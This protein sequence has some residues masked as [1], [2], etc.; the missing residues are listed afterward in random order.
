MSCCSNPDNSK[1]EVIPFDDRPIGYKDLHHETVDVLP[2]WPPGARPPGARP[3][4]PRP[5]GGSIKKQYSNGYDDAD[6]DRSCMAA[7]GIDLCECV[8]DRPGRRY[9]AQARE[10]RD[11]R[12]ADRGLAPDELIIADSKP[13]LLDLDHA[14]KRG[15][16]LVQLDASAGAFLGL[17][18]VEIGT[19]SGTCLKIS[20]VWPD[21][22]MH[23]WNCRNPEGRR[24]AEGDLILSVNSVSGDSN[25][26]LTE[27]HETIGTMELRVRKGTYKEMFD[28]LMEIDMALEAAERSQAA[29]ERD[30]NNRRLKAAANDADRR[31]EELKRKLQEP[32]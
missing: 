4:P 26:L 23:G 2:E 27:F 13:A 20:K 8:E 9:P 24:V 31:V 10:Q 1:E 21:S 14:P 22:V 16:F 28:E 7:S 11:Y 15:D 3:R 5:T 18:V 29:L 17:T 30:P 32:L 19:Y 25:L 6:D 12:Y